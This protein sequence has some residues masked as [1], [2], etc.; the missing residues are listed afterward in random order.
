MAKVFP[1]WENINRLRV[2]PEEGERYLL[3]YLECHLSDDYE[4]FFNPFLDGDRPDIIILR[5]SY[6]AVVIEI[7]DWDLRSYNVDAI[8]SWFVKSSKIRSPQQQAF[9]Y[10][11]NLFDLHIPILGLSE[12][13]NKNFYNVIDVFVY[14]HNASNYQLSS[15]YEPAQNEIRAII[16]DTN[17]HREEYDFA[18]YEKKIN[19]WES[20]KKQISRDLSISICKNL[21]DEKIKKIRNITKNN[22]FTDDVYQ[23]FRRRLMPPSQVLEQGI[24]IPFDSKQLKLSESKS[25]FSKIKGVAGCGKTSIL[26]QRAINALMRH[27]Q[28]VLILTYNITIRFYIKDVISRIAG[29]RLDNQIE[30]IHYHGFINEKINQYGIVIEDV[31]SKIQEDDVNKVYSYMDLF[32]DKKTDRYES[33]FIDEVQDYEPNWIKIIRDYFLDSDGEMVLFGDQSQNIYD[34]E[35]SKRASPIVLGFGEWNKLTKSYRSSIDAPLVSMFSAFQRDFLIPKYSDAEVFES[36]PSQSGLNFDVLNYE[37]FSN[38]F[39]CL[40]VLDRINDHIRNYDFHPND[41]AIISSQVDPLLQI[42]TLLSKFE[43]TK[44]MFETQEELDSLNSKKLSKEAFKTHVEK[45]RRRKKSFFYQNSGVI[46]LSTIHSFKGLEAESVFLILVPGD[47]AEVVY[48]GI[49]R[50][51]KNLIVFDFGKSDFHQF[52]SKYM[53]LI[54]DGVKL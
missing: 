21:L 40:Y 43:A 28:P 16:S 22:L 31:L 14:F 9:R 6:G 41:V 20:K 50:A 34:R 39:N 33:I 17:A 2:Q 23:D 24:K 5:K 47:N 51:K 25:G 11:S 8:N 42:N 53:S 54:S 46:K 52:F 26:A 29:D 32:K 4:I 10:K 1:D 37:Y 36:E 18:E 30:V 44:V 15:L 35:E 3:E 48:T 38:V 19:F 13:S 45:I 7:K 12:L 49:T 27:G